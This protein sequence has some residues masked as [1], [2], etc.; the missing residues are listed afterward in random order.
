[1]VKFLKR[2]IQNP[3][4]SSAGLAALAT[5]GCMNLDGY[6]HGAADDTFQGG[7]GNAGA[8]GALTGGSTM[9]GTS[10][11]GDSSVGGAF[12]AGGVGAFPPQ[13]GTAAS[14]AG[15]TGGGV[16]ANG[17]TRAGAGSTSTGPAVTLGGTGGSA[18]CADGSEGCRCYGNGTCNGSLTCASSLCVAAGHGGGSANYSGV[19]SARGGATTTGISAGGAGATGFTAMSGAATGGAAIGGSGAGGTTMTGAGAGSEALGGAAAGSTALCATFHETG[20][21]YVPVNPPSCPSS[22]KTVCQGESCCMS[23]AMPG[24]SF[25]MGRKTEDCGIVGCQSGVGN[26][27]CPVGSS[28]DL[29]NERPEHNA[30]VAAFALD[31]YEVTVGRFRAFANTYDDW[32]ATRGFPKDND[33]ANPTAADTGWARS[34]SAASD[35]L[36]ATADALRSALS[37][38]SFF[39][40]WTT[41]PGPNESFPINCVS[42]YVAFAFCTWDGGRLPTEAEWEYAAAGGSQNRLYPWGSVAPDYEHANYNESSPSGSLFTIVGSRQPTGDG[43]FGHA[44]LA[45]SLSEWVVDWFNTYYYQNSNPCNNCVNADDANPNRAV[46]GGGW[47]A[48][49]DLF[50]AAGRT[51]SKPSDPYHALGFRC[52]RN[53]P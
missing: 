16:T 27:G 41:N 2:R 10:R 21:S 49:V 19:S 44:D 43:Y 37:C 47:I 23:I 17:G 13:G 12:H 35:D 6:R 22:S 48:G 14:G 26:E 33:G 34:W 29:S 30:T 50:R 28:C 15:M 36:P 51:L 7:A 4:L 18:S 3:A 5:C 31:K 42:W 8:N 25:L 53:V 39:Y 52:A 46:R 24:G 9:L 11:A 1:M 40:T 20:C 45:G 32:H 38:D